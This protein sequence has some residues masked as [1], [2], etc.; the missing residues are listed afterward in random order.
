M[1]TSSYFLIRSTTVTLLEEQGFTKQEALHLIDAETEYLTY[2][3][4]KI[5]NKLS[6]KRKEVDRNKIIITYQKQKLIEYLLG[7]S[8]ISGASYDE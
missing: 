7:L 4:R 1:L 5:I 3:D 8:L 6:L 2:K